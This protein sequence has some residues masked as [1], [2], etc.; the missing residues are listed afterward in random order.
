MIVLVLCNLG[1][2]GTISK[3]KSA[4]LVWVFSWLWE[5]A[6]LVVYIIYFFTL[7]FFSAYHQCEE[8]K[9]CSLIQ[10]EQ[11]KA[12]FSTSALASGIHLTIIWV[13]IFTFSHNGAISYQRW[14]FNGVWRGENHFLTESGW[15]WTTGPCFLHAVTQPAWSCQ[16][17]MLT[18]A[19]LG[20]YA[21]ATGPWLGPAL[22]SHCS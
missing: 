17:K 5:E 11:Y 6:R 14:F 7:I 9:T 12:W 16:E 1:W 4:H 20:R 15:W 22:S 10:C 3:K 8:Q 2:S 18:G 21:L 19:S 13:Y